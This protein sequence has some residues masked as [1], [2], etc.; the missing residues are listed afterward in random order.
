MLLK[1]SKLL[2][3]LSFYD[4]TVSVPVV[5][6]AVARASAVL[7]ASEAGKDLIRAVA[8][9]AACDEVLERA[10]SSFVNRGY[11]TE[12][13]N[14]IYRDLTD[15]TGLELNVSSPIGFVP[16]KLVSLRY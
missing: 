3:N 11:A 1:Y 4:T 15:E 8:K 2:V 16:V 9:V 13:I 10:S 7:W 5:V 14:S 6:V 12:T